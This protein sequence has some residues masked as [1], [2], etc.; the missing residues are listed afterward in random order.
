MTP[1][2]P[3][4]F[5]INTLPI[6]RVLAALSISH[7]HKLNDAI[8]L[9]WQNFWVEYNDPTKPENMLAIMSKILGSEEEAKKVVEASKSAEGKE[10]LKSNT[11]RSFEEGA[12]G[13]PWFVGK[14]EQSD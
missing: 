6:E 7:P 12:F 1:G 2:V 9:F 5:P 10:R 3:D 13:V 14:L 4:G 8:S 11:D